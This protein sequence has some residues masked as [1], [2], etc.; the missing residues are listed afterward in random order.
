MDFL[1]L[2]VLDLE[3]FKVFAGPVFFYCSNFI[4]QLCNFVTKINLLT[5]FG[6]KFEYTLFFFVRKVL[7]PKV[8]SPES[9]QLFCLWTTLA[10]WMSQD[11]NIWGKIRLIVL[12]TVLH[13]AGWIMTS[14]HSWTSVSQS[15]NHVDCAVILTLYARKL[16]QWENLRHKIKC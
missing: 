14:N 16:Y 6:A 10:S 3:H 2:I 13:C 7:H 11:H 5:I 1:D 4:F 12:C 8:C 15:Q 9:F